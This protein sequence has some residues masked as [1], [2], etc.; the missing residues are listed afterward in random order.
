[1]F[2]SKEGINTN[3]NLGLKPAK[4]GE[5]GYHRSR[6]MSQNKFRNNSFYTYVGTVFDM[7]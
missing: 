6:I 4:M 7:A 5:L 3:S 2:L 1:M